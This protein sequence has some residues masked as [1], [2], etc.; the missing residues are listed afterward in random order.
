MPTSKEE[1]LRRGLHPHD[2]Q[3]NQHRRAEWQDYSG[4][5]LYM[6]T[7]C[8]EGRH[9]LFGYL[10]GDIRAQRGSSAFPH[11]VLSSLG[12]AV[13]EEEL[14]P[15]WAYLM[16]VVDILVVAHPELYRG[17]AKHLGDGI[18]YDDAALV[19]VGN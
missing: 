6:I 12:H 16:G 8:I 19:H 18:R 10:E 1:L 15:T 9:G 3:H 4:T 11:I 13:V 2:I 7:L 17:L 14:T 5:G